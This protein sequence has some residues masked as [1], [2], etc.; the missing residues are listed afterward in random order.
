MRRFYCMLLAASA[1]TLLS[2]AAANAQAGQAP[3][4]ESVAAE[5]R[6][7]RAELVERLDANIQAQLLVA[8]LQI[9][10]QRA[11]A[12]NRQL[13][14]IVD[15]LREA[16]Q[17]KALVEASMR[18]LGVDP[19][20]PGTTQGFMVAPMAKSLEQLRQSETD[21]RQQQAA[22]MTMVTDEQ[23]RWS[24]L[25]ARLDELERRFADPQR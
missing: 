11:T 24:S 25:Y 17:Q 9:Q 21:L 2:I 18:G 7:L 12:V 20:D 4:S 8:R 5:I 16:E 10:E 23:A 15:R 1:V 22:L 3:A 14:D 6:A 19:A 13:E